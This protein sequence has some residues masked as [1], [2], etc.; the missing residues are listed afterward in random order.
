[1]IGNARSGSTVIGASCGQLVERRL[2]H[3]ARL[4]V[5]LGAAR[6]ALR[7]LAVPAHGEVRRCRALDLVHRVEDDHA[8]AGP[9][10][11]YATNSP[12]SASPRQSSNVRVLT[13]SPPPSA[14]STSGSSSATVTTG[15]RST[16]IA[17]PSPLA[18][19]TL[20]RAH[21]SSTPGSRAGCARR[22]SRA[23]ERRARDRLG[24]DEHVP[25]VAA[26]VPA[27]VERALRPTDAH[28][29]GAAARASSSS[30]DRRG[31]AASSRKMPTFACIVAC[32]SACSA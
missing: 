7:R 9:R 22:G 6:A 8:L 2:A 13:R 30:S 25:Q 16:R 17:S 18:T 4:A 24:A 23:Q 11:S 27:G 5:H 12:P 14:R 15:R 32:S 19:T 3:E 31:Q 26:E 10:A 20:C 29:R 1:M 28:A 21:S